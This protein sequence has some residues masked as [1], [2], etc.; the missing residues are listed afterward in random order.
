MGDMITLTAKDGVEIEAYRAR[1]HRQTARRHRRLCRRFSASIITSGTSPTDLRWPAI[2]SSRRRSSTGSRRISNSATGRTTSKR[3]GDSR[4]NEIRRHFL[5]DIEAAVAV[6]SEAG[7]VGVVG[8]CWGGTLAYAAATHLHGISAAVCY[9]GSGIAAMRRETLLAP[10]QFHFG[11]RDKSIPPRISRRSARP[12]PTAR[13]ISIRRI[14]VSVAASAR[15]MTRRAP[16]W[17]KAVRSNFLRH[18][19]D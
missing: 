10:T 11:E 3:D 19:L 9:Y 15:A 18:Y 13:S 2:S 6:A 1:A 17:R 8:Y 7:R 14:T 4:Q 12:I 16:N 5:A